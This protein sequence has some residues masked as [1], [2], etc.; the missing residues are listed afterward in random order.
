[1]HSQRFHDLTDSYGSD[2]RRWPEADRAAAQSFIDA[3]PEEA[4]AALAGAADLD[5][6]L[7]RS[8]V[9]APSAALRERIIASAPRRAAA[10]LGGFLWRGLGLAGIGVAG[11]AAGMVL[12]GFVVTHSPYDADDGA[13]AVTAFTLAADEGD[14]Q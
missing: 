4:H 7:D 14:V 1:M 2:L 12:A 13:Y 10:G 9:P 11:A 6:L 8:S 5:R 3:H